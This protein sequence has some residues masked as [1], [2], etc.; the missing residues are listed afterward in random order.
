VRAPSRNLLTLPADTRPILS[1][2][3]HTEEE[4]DWNRAFDRAATGVTHARHLHRA[5]ELFDRFQ[6]RPTYVVDYPIADQEAGAAPL[7]VFA[8]EGRALIGAHLHPWVSPPYEEEVCPRNSYPGNLPRELEAK[9]LALLTERIGERFGCPPRVYLA[10]RYGFGPNTA[11]ILKELS[12]EVDVSPAP[13]IDFRFDEGPDYSGFSN[14]PYWLDGQGSLLGLPGTGAYLGALHPLGR[15]L[16]PLVTDARLSRLR[17]PGILSRL[18]LLERV[19]LSPEGYTLAEQIRLTRA[20]LRRGIRI[21]VYSFHS[22]S[23]QPGHTPYVRSERDLER[24]LDA[25]RGYLAF[26]RDELGGIGMT[27][28]Q[29]KAYLQAHASSPPGPAQP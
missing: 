20:L 11:A 26:F 5:Q 24:F 10:G 1:V 2:V 6:V 15:S 14:H 28:L 27:P 18:R 12:Y 13:P 17:L 29:I 25:V 8:D 19:R 3:I 7:K 22:P 23:V 21:V 4:F 9:K 16:Y